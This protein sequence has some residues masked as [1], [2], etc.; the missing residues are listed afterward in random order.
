MMDQLIIHRD[1]TISTIL[2][3]SNVNS[4]AFLDTFIPFLAYTDNGGQFFA[5]AR[6]TLPAMGRSFLGSP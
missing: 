3:N 5:I 4:G 6:K 1:A 2:A